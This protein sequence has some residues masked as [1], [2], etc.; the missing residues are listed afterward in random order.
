MVSGREAEICP[1]CTLFVCFSLL[2][3]RVAAA[4]SIVSVCFTKLSIVFIVSIY[5]IVAF[6]GVLTFNVF[7]MPLHFDVMRSS[8]ERRI[9]QLEQEVLDCCRELNKLKKEK[10]F[11]ENQDMFINYMRTETHLIWKFD[12]S[13]FP[14]KNIKLELKNK[15]IKLQAYRKQ[16]GQFMEVYRKFLLP[17]IVEI[18]LSA[19]MAI[20]GILTIQAPLK[21]TGD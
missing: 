9:Q 12:M 10:Q 18:D 14:V 20:N 1:I 15:C 4:F 8:H 6:A 3:N 17:D 5:R 11:L 13:E 16:K 19:K 7:T 21:A 2:L